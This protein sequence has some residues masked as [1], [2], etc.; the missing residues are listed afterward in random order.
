M[1]QLNNTEWKTFLKDNQNYTCD[2]YY[3]TDTNQFII[4]TEHPDW[5]EYLRVFTDAFQRSEYPDRVQYSIDPNFKLDI[6]GWIDKKLKQHL[7]YSINIK[8]YEAWAIEYKDGGYQAIHNHTQQSNL[9]SMIM[10]FDTIT[11]EQRRQP[12]DG[13]TYTLMPQTDGN[14]MCSHFNPYPGKVI[15]FDGKVYHGTYPC[16]A[17]RRCFVVNF[18]FEYITMEPKID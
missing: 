6:T 2:N 8:P 4:E 15:I 3:N 7:N 10:F 13:C 16:K 12:T 5:K 1:S 14:Q 11:E 9:I 18:K 17:P